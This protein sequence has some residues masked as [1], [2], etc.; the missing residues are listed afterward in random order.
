MSDTPTPEPEVPPE[1]PDIP[2]PLGPNPGD[3]D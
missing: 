2:D 1:N 3:D